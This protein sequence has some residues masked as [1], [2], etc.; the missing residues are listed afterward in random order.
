MTSL[1]ELSVVEV[2]V[3]AE[4]VEVEAEAEAESTW[5][6]GARTVVVASEVG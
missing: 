5:A 4:V 2:V 3:E 6:F 1:M